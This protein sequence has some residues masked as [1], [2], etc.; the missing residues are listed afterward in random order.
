MPPQAADRDAAMYRRAAVIAGVFLS[1]LLVSALVL[2]WAA[3]NSGHSVGDNASTAGAE[4]NDGTA[5]RLESL[6][7]RL[8]EPTAYALR[9]SAPKAEQ[10]LREAPTTERPPEPKPAALTNDTNPPHPTP[11]QTLIKSTEEPPPPPVR[12]PSP[13]PADNTGEAF[14]DKGKGAD[15]NSTTCQRYGTSVDFVDSP[16][17]AAARALKDNK[18]VFVLHV[19]GNFEDDKFT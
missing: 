1:F 9:A 18:L 12:P 8:P 6:E 4:R 15:N 13:P 11:T 2:A 10:T 16:T 3:R 17:E 7:N 19:A 5:G 14:V